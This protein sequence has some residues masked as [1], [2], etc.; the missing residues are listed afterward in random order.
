MN[1]RHPGVSRGQITL[2]PHAKGASAAPGWRAGCRQSTALEAQ[3]RLTEGYLKPGE[4]PAVRAGV[5]NVCRPGAASLRLPGPS[6]QTQSSCWPGRGSAR[7]QRGAEPARPVHSGAHRLPT[8]PVAL[9]RKH[10]GSAQRLL[11]RGWGFLLRCDD[12]VGGLGT[13]SETTVWLGSYYGVA[14]PGYFPDLASLLSREGDAV[15]TV[16]AAVGTKRGDGEEDSGTD[17]VLEKC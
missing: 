10:V 9:C 3:E 8:G 14:W 11:H 1:S 16:Q 15:P 7:A 2:R 5:G 6:L 12:P 13:V 17:K 4:G